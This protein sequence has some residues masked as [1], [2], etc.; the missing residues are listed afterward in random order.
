MKT[1]FCE[2]I[3]AKQMLALRQYGVGSVYPAGLRPESLG[4]L[5]VAG[6]FRGKN[7]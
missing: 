5:R 1:P 7:V 2:T 4:Q 3:R 6:V